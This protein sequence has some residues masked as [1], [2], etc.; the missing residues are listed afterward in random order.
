VLG[1]KAAE[2]WVAGGSLQGDLGPMGVRAEGHVGIPDDD[3]DGR[4][5]ADRHRPV[6]GR[7]AVGPNFNV[8]WQQLTVAAEYG[9]LSDGTLRPGDDLARATRL[10]PDD[11]PYL[12]QHYAS[13][14]ASLEIVPVLR[15]SAL[16]LVDAGDGSGITGLTFLYNVADEA[17]LIA[18]AFIPWGARTT[19]ADL[20][21][22]PPRLA[23]EFGLS[24]LSIYLEARVFF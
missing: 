17:D 7:L 12:G 24:P 9:F 20:A 2:R 22:L 8:D 14:S 23:S 1:G 6:Y 5:D 19:N 4:D 18:G 16:G 15:G 3:G 10:F 11:V 13:L 21:A